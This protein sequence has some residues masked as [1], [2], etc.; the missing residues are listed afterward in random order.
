M[1]KTFTIL[2]FVSFV[3][4]FA[5]PLIDG[6]FDGEGVWGTPIATADLTPGFAATNAKRVYVTYDINYIYLGA[7][8]TASTWNN[9][10]FIINTKTGGSGTDSWLR[11][12]SYSHSNLPDFDAR[13]HFNGYA[14]IHSWNG[15]SSSWDRTPDVALSSTEYAENIIGSDQDGWVE[16]RVPQ[17]TMNSPSIGDIQF[18]ICGDNNVHGCFDACPND[19]NANAWTYHSYLKNYTTNIPLPVEL[20]SLTAKNVG[21]SVVLNWETA[22]EVNNHGFDVEASNDNVNWNFIGFV[23]GNG[24]SNSPKSYSFVAKEGS[25]YYRLKQ[26]DTDGGFEYSDVVEVAAELS[27]KLAQ[28]HPNPFNPTTKINFSI[29]EVAKVSITVFNALGQEVAE[30]ANR[31]FAVGNHSIEFNASNLNSGIYFYRLQ[32]SNYSKTMKMLLIK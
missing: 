7:E 11:N 18:Y 26:I 14:E 8:V 22:T 10:V 25:Q 24:N 29:P 32:S 17:S 6:T 31:E 16:I 15:T 4:L 2:F 30:L 9:W 13:G 3:G 23:E 21:G 1:K 20:T 19:D 28:N 12:I 5:Q 27:Y